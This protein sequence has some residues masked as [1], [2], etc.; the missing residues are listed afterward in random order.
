MT[1]SCAV[2]KSVKGEDGKLRFLE[3]MKKGMLLET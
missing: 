3:G 2:A 1:K